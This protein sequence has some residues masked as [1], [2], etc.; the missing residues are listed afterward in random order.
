MPL[1][2]TQLLL[3][4]FL[5]AHRESAIECFMSIAQEGLVMLAKIRECYYGMLDRKGDVADNL[6]PIVVTSAN[7]T[8]QLPHALQSHDADCASPF[9][10]D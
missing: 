7:N 5:V 6:A 10:I 4:S 8:N 9:H 3:L 2:H 1:G